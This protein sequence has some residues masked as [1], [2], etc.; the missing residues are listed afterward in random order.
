M[1]LEEFDAIDDNLNRLPESTS[2]FSAKS[3]LDH[4]D[5]EWYSNASRRARW[6]DLLGDYAGEETFLIDGSFCMLWIFAF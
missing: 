6:M 2:T 3:A 4:L 1:D 5:K